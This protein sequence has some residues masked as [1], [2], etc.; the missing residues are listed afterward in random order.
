MPRWRRYIEL[1]AG[2][3][4]GATAVGGSRVGSGFTRKPNRLDAR[5]EP[6]RSGNAHPN[7]CPYDTFVTGGTP[8]RDVHA[9]DSLARWRAVSLGRRWVTLRWPR[10]QIN[11]PRQAP[12]AAA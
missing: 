6:G 1:V 2:A 10:A 11:A 9:P 5:I 8:I 4:L 3:T 12:V 7:P